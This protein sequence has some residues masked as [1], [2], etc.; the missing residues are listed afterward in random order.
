MQ[1]S[2]LKY[3][4]EWDRNVSA[5]TSHILEIFFYQALSC[6]MVDFSSQRPPV[7]QIQF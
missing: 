2:L 3:S 4:N 1:E 5:S 7:L 6:G